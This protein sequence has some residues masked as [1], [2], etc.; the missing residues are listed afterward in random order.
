MTQLVAFTREV[1]NDNINNDAC[2]KQVPI[3]LPLKWCLTF[4]A[5]V[6]KTDLEKVK[7]S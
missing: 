4:I 5:E 2:E 1:N 3:D 6:V 7:T